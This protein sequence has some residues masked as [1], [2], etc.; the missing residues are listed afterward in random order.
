MQLRPPDRKPRKKFF[1]MI[2]PGFQ[3]RSLPVDIFSY[4]F[5]NFKNVLS[6]QIIN[7]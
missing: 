7:F 2:Y 4:R 1:S 3:I 6:V 5:N